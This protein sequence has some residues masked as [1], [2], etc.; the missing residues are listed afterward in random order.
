MLRREDFAAFYSQAHGGFTPFPWQERLLDR[1]LDTGWPDLVDVPTGLGKT[2]ILDVAVFAAALGSQRARR[3]VFF[4]VDRRLIVDEA[5]RHAREIQDALDNGSVGS[6]A[7][8]VAAALRVPGDERVLEVTRMR[9]GV[10]WSWRWL[11]RPDRQAIVVG[12]V[13][14]VGSRLLFRGYGLG[15]NLRPIDAGLVG[16]DSLI[17]VDEAHLSQ[18]F[19]TTARQAVREEPAGLLPLPVIVSMTAS[20]GAADSDIFRIDG[21]DQAHPVAGRRLRAAKRAHLVQMAGVTKRTSEQQT[22]ETLA[23]WARHFAGDKP[24]VGVICNTVNRARAVFELLHAAHPDRCVLLTGRVRPVDRNYLL[25]EWYDRIKAGRAGEPPEPVFVCATQTVEV[26]ANIDFSALVSDSASLAALIQRLGR[27]NRLGS[28]GGAAPAVIVHNPVDPPGVYGPA[29]AATWEW[30]CGLH[31]PMDPAAAELPEAGIDVSPAALRELV[32]RLATEDP[33]RWAETQQAPVYTPFLSATHLDAWAA[34]SPIPSPDPPVAPFLHGLQPD[35]P[36]V[37]LC[38]RELPE[39]EGYWPAG[40]E[41]VPPSAEECIELPLAAVRGWLAG[42]AAVPAFSD[43]EGEA[44]DADETFPAGGPGRPGTAGAVRRV[45][46]YGSRQEIEV[47]DGEKIR[48]GDRIVVPAS[49]GGCDAYGWNPA[50]TTPVLD[51][52]DLC[53]GTGRRPAT[54]R[55]GPTLVNAVAA[56][57]P[58]LAA[59]LEELVR[60]VEADRRAETLR[61]RDYT[62]DLA[63]A[64]RSRPDIVARLGQDLG[65]DGDDL[66]PHLAVLRRLA[67]AAKPTAKEHLVLDC[68]VLTSDITVFGE[69]DTAYGSS[70]A[71]RKLTLAEHQMAVRRRAEEF[72]RNLGLPD[73]IAEAI[74]LA[75]YWH[76][77]GK[78]D[79]R[80]QAMLH[81]GDRWAAAAAPHV[82]AKSGMN[83]VDRGLRRRARQLSGYPEG[84]RHEAL[85]AQ[86]VR[87]LLDDVKSADADLVVHLVAAHHGHSRP[88][89]PP[90]IDPAPVT[91][92]ERDGEV[93][94]VDTARSIDWDAPRRFH[95]LMSRY[96]RWGLAGLEAVVRLADIWCSAREEDGT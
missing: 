57:D 88:L 23:Q 14:Q 62:A 54:V 80:F 81:E 35:S 53:G 87:V 29:R 48:A 6:V 45:I 41:L 46:R 92:V 34:T 19:L 21:A 79:E 82:L 3:R 13:D 86:I 90:I 2:S 78:R 85:S 36:Q 93:I 18:P 75:G 16:T 12:T 37:S 67:R 77:E 20:P 8:Q 73:E 58:Q 15:D 65:H 4:V 44:G 51:V 32:G 84:M 69:E 22:A 76:D 60:D 56:H 72:A 74:G 55:L 42:L 27:L 7:G 33:A 52:G 38:W 94:E 31:P 64:L 39:D 68:V 49:Y 91:F 26:G 28:A 43:I 71:R 47:I 50:S 96:G 25:L 40:I 17:V 59:P 89:L 61:A 5:Y 11:E 63:K 70:L 66:P 9:G 10:T 83:P 24:V 1:V 30:L 95:D